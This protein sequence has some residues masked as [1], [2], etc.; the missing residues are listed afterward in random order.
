MTGPEDGIP[1]DACEA[2]AKMIK[3]NKEFQQ[4]PPEQ[5][6]QQQQ[7]QQ[8]QQQQQHQQQPQPQQ[9]QPFAMLDPI[10]A[11]LESLGMY[12]AHKPF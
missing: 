7:H 1:L 11:A 6:Q 9:Q 12:V 3:R 4:H 10:L 2:I 8:Q 5:Q